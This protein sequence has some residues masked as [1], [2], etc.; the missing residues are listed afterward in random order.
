[1]VISTRKKH[2]KLKLVSEI[3]IHAQQYRHILKGFDYCI[4]IKNESIADSLKY[5]SKINIFQYIRYIKTYLL[6]CAFKW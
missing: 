1:M 3:T 2:Y 4:T 6:K 5:V